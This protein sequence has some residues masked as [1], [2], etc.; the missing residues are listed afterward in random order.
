MLRHPKYKSL[1]ITAFLISVLFIVVFAVSA[2]RIGTV[3]ASSPGYAASDVLGQLTG[4]VPDFTTHTPTTTS[5]G[6][7]FP[8]GTALDLVH[9]HLFVAD[10]SNNRVVVYNLDANN[11]LL[12]HTADYVLGQ[13]DFMSSGSSIATQSSLKLPY[14]ALAFDNQNDRLFVSDNNNHRIMVYDLANGISD[15]MLAANVLGQPDFTT[16]N[17]VP[18]RSGMHHPDGMAFDS[19]HQRLFVSDVL[20]ARVTVY[21]VAPGTIS[22]GM[23]ASHVLGQT[24]FTTIS[25][26]TSQN[27][28]SHP[29]AMAYNNVTQQLFVGDSHNFRLLV[30]NLDNGI[31]DGMNA[32]YVLGQTDFTSTNNGSVTQSNL[33]QYIEGMGVDTVRNILYVQDDD[34]NRILVFNLA[35]GIT[36]NMNASQV[37]G[38]VDMTSSDYSCVAT[39]TTLCDSEGSIAVDPVND[40]IYVPDSNFNRMLV[41]NFAHFTSPAGALSGGTIDTSY[42]QSV[43][44][45]GGQCTQAFSKTSGSLPPGLSLN[46]ATGHITGT[47]TTAGTYAFELA[48]SDNCGAT[49]TST[50]DPAYSITIASSGTP[51]NTVSAPNTGYGKP[52]NHAV[53]I[54]IAVTGLVTLCLGLRFLSKQS[55]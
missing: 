26:T 41:Y 4:G 55:R 8:T 33:S 7:S 51:L 16:T 12:D 38:Q 31:T 27:G 1:R 46:T 47:P 40:R 45:N 29:E 18:D 3:F 53:Q 49:G 24:D 6:L 50:D 39:V 48:L 5:T 30:F 20:A 21:D 44:T 35:N 22:D 15:N 17:S 32:S 42:D 34:F 9:H 37:I 11:N 14:D 10:E 23:D 52:A 19:V 13:L 54:L 36:N 2:S 28:F 43:Q 25:A